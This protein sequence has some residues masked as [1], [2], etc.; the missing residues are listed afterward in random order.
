M[1][2]VPSAPAWFVGSLEVGFSIIAS[3]FGSAVAVVDSMF[4]GFESSAGGVVWEAGGPEESAAGCGW[5]GDL[6]GEAAELIPFAS[7]DGSA[8]WLFTAVE[9]V[10]PFSVA[11]LVGATGLMS[12]TESCG[13]KRLSVNTPQS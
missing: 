1:A 4:D 2:V 8:L 12:V 6:G 7:E 9:S 5:S 11:P 10:I 13:L 3:G